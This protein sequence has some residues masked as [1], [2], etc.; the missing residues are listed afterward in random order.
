M[1]LTLSGTNATIN[2]VTMNYTGDFIIPSS[3]FIG[4]T[5]YYITIIGSDSFYNCKTLANLTIP[6]GITTIERNAF[7]SSSVTGHVVIPKTVTS[8]GYDI[9]ARCLGLTEVTIL[10]PITTWGGDHS[11]GEGAF[12]RCTNLKKVNLAEGITVIGECAFQNCSS[13]EE[14]IIPNSVQTIGHYAF[15]YCSSATTVSIGSG[16]TKIYRYTFRGLSSATNIYF[17]NSMDSV[18]HWGSGT[19]G[20]G[21]ANAVYWFKTQADLDVAL[22]STAEFTTTNFELILNKI[23][24]EVNGGQEMAEITITPDMTTYGTLPTPTRENYIFVGWYL[25]S[26]FITEIKTNTPLA[27]QE[28]HTIYARWVK[29]CNLTVNPSLNGQILVISEDYLLTD[30]VAYQQ[31]IKL[32]AIAIPGKA[33]SHWEIEGELFTDT[34]LTQNPLEFSATN[35]LIITAY[36]IDSVSGIAIT[37]TYG[38][39]ALIVGADFDNLTNEDEI[40]V[41]ANIS[42]ENYE[43]AGWY[44]S[45]DM[46]NCLSMAMSQKFKKSLIFNKQLIAVFRPI[47]NLNLNTSLNN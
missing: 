40:I 26:T 17:Y 37:S 29:A 47:S 27:S 21:N 38:G 35:D 34:K 28:D 24:L 7:E 16:V 33:F 9:F 46:E 41:R 31:I 14:I 8:I 15:E 5:R 44:L 36:F 2:K 10:G 20:S 1:E 42:V 43:F 45:G 13:L 19:F 32:Y 18:F 3:I 6:E 11:D 12:V 39:T 4:S 22:A 25:E 30:V 23:F